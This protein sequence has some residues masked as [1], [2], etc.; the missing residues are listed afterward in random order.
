MIDTVWPAARVLELLIPSKFVLGD[1]ADS[2]TAMGV[3][4]AKKEGNDCMEKVFGG[5]HAR[6]SSSQ[7]SESEIKG[8]R[9]GFCQG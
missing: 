9:T 5:S 1:P 6:H 7:A 2:C 8:I 3:V 4:R